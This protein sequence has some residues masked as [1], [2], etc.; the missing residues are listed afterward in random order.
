MK[1]A[2]YRFAEQAIAKRVSVIGAVSEFEAEQARTTAPRARI[3]VVP[4][5]IAELDNPDEDAPDRPRE[6]MVVV[7][8]RIGQQRNPEGTARILAQ[9]RDVARAVWIGAEP[10]PGRASEVLRAAGVEITGW[11]SHR[12]TTEVMRR[13][14]AVLHWSAWEGQS[15]ALLEALA[16]S[17]PVVA[18]DIGPNR[19]VLGAEQVFSSEADAA[20]ALRALVCEDRTRAR[21]LRNQNQRRGFYS[22]R[23]MSSEWIGLYRALADATHE[24]LIPLTRQGSG[25]PGEE[26]LTR[27][28]S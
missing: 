19:E 12:A 22:A 13:A 4:N 1:N 21:Y 28:S 23:R 5:G 3:A 2:A 26:S 25:G 10:S 20:R 15:L 7:V 24:P 6:P 9:V 27:H 14:M 17:V 18:S 16:A 8:G 11:L